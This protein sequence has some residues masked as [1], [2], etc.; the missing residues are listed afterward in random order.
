MRAFTVSEVRI[1]KVAPLGPRR[2]ASGIDKYPA[3]GPLMARTTGLDGDELG[4]PRHHGGAGKALHAYPVAHYAA[5]IDDLP[6]HAA[7][8]RP[9]AFGENLV[10]A[11]ATEADVCLFDR[12]RIGGAEVEVS[13]TRQPCWKLNLRFDRPDMARRVQDTGRTGWYF[14]VLS[15][16]VIAPGD[17][18]EP[19]ARP[20]PDWPLRRVWRLL[21]RDTLDLA[22]LA[23][24][25][26][27]P[28]LPESWQRAVDARL[29]RHRVEDWGA[30]L[31]TPG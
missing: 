3:P 22:A 27:L 6:E 19:M 17:R 10:I 14:R 18:A 28:G 24:F 12:Y 8:F 11:D 16:G 15:E 13:Q 21:Y 4:D 9:G 29:A 20:H 31:E 5:W 25:A 30:R 1:G 26:A 23:D 7:R 2:V